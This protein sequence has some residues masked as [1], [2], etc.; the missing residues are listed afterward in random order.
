[1]PLA[2]ATVVARADPSQ[3]Q[4]TSS[5][6]TDTSFFTFLIALLI[7]VFASGALILR[8]VLLRRR[9]RRR[10]QEAIDAGMFPH[11]PSLDHKPEL[12]EVCV[13]AAGDAMDWR[14]LMP[15]CASNVGAPH[16]SANKRIKDTPSAA[17]RFMSQLLGG[18]LTPPLLTQQS[19]PSHEHEPD[20]K[21]DEHTPLQVAVLIAMP[22]EHPHI[23]FLESGPPAVSPNGKRRDSSVNEDTIPDVLFGVSTVAVIPDKSDLL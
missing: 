13:R 1:M 14:T 9:F 12:Y 18:R 21:N 7:L 10:V 19:A 16:Q 2:S 11:P 20:S 5:Q 3:T 23:P 17:G 4:A 8:A 22:S 15:I 6:H